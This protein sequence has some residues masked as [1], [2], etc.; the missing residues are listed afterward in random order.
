MVSAAKKTSNTANTRKTKQS[1]PVRLAEPF[2]KKMDAAARINS[3]S[4][5]KQLE[6][7]VNIAESVGEHVSRE[8][9]LDIQAGLSKIV[10]EKIDAPRVDKVSLFGTLDSMRQSGA[11]SQAVTRAGNKYQASKSHP[12][13]LERINENGNLETGMFVNGKFKVNKELV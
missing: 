12:G 6:H 10:I 4:I 7:M 9:L 8:E 11:L 5:P 3:R 1:S 13:Y 2:Y